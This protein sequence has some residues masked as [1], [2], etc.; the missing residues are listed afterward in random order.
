MKCFAMT[1][2]VLG[3]TTA[4][5]ADESTQ[6]EV[7]RGNNRFALDLYGK[8]RDREG[9][10]FFSPY[11]IST[12]LAMT[13]AGARG[14]TAAEMARTLRFEVPSEQLHPAFAAIGKALDAEGS[15][16]GYR[17]SMANRLWG[18]QGDHFLPDFLALTRESYGAELAPVDF[19]SQTA[20]A[21]RAINSWVEQRTQSKIKDLIQPGDLTDRTR[22]VLT[23][24][25][26]FKGR[27]SEPFETGATEEANFHVD[28]KQDVRVPMMHRTSG[29]A[30]WAGDGLKVVALPYSRGDLSMVILLPDKADGMEALEAGLTAKNLAKWLDGLRPNEVKVSLPR[31]ATSSRFKLA[32]V[33]KAM[34]M[35][36]AFSPGPSDFSGISTEEDLSLSEVIHQAFVDVNE[37]GTEAAAATAVVQSPP[38]P[39]PPPPVEFRADHPFVFLIRDKARGS[40]LFLGRVANPRG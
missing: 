14:E 25:I 17:L 9:N 21:R 36:Q 2:L 19:A 8:V 11:S 1:L 5:R 40:I 35:S 4:G 31:F 30:Y 13:Y 27:W 39:V 28:A 18:Q 37:E 20:S 38:S 33:L 22:L 3:A 34:G 23:N 24:A 6:A 29:L 12:A 26:Y 16:R 32:D 7:V 10:I 15:K